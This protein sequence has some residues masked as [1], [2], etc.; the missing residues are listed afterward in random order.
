MYS[1][2]VSNSAAK[3]L[4]R[5]YASDNKIYQR[6]IAVIESLR[7]S[8]Y[9][10][11]KLKGELSGN[12]SVRVGNYRVIYSVYKT[13]LLIHIIDIGHRREIYR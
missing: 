12:Y 6:L 11:K 10:G 3:E 8:P 4:E 13:R 7:S 9:Q 5:I 2:E 1:I